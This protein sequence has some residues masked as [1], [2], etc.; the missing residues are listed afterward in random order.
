MIMRLKWSVRSSLIAVAILGLSLA[1]VDAMRIHAKVKSYRKRA[2]SLAWLEQINLR[3]DAMDDTARAQEAKEGFDD[4]YLDNPAW[5]R[6][7]IA[8]NRSMKEKYQFAAKHPRL[9][10]APDPPYP[11]R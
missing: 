11:G 2:E 5:N 9:S 10:V 6:N 4:P 7:M 1:V 3:I 8:Y